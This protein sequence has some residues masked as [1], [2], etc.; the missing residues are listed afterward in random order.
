MNKLDKKKKFLRRE[1]IMI[2]ILLL[3]IFFIILSMSFSYY[4]HSIDA[5]DILFKISSMISIVLIILFIILVII[6]AE[7]KRICPICNIPMEKEVRS[8]LF[9]K[10]K[11]CGFS[12]NTYI[13]TSSGGG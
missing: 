13:D 7:R 9:Y 11:K 5:N 2:T 1:R 12:I 10:C 6:H 8:Q 3:I 4:W